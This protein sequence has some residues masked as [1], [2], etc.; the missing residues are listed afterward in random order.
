[1][2]MTVYNVFRRT[3]MMTEYEKS[4]SFKITNTNYQLSPSYLYEI[5]LLSKTPNWL[6]Q[7]NR[8]NLPVAKIRVKKI[9]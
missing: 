8:N 1:M 6:S 9:G 7:V 3:A 2:P 5:G 4:G